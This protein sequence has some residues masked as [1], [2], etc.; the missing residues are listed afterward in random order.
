[1]DQNNVTRNILQ[2]VSAV[3]RC[4]TEGWHEE[5]FRQH[6][7]PDIVAV[8][9]DSPGRIEGKEAYVAEWRGFCSMAVVS[10]R[11]ETGHRVSIFS[12][13]KAA[14][15]TYL[16]TVTFVMDGREQVM[17]GRDMFFLVKEGR[18]WLVAAQQFSAEPE[19]VVPP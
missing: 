17:Q 16:F 7:H 2:T 8:F 19:G 10:R 1:M 12:G 9:P 14:V 13:G 6:I 3:N 4:Y 5:E 18:K 15:V 11:Q